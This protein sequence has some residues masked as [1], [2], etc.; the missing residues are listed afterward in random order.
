MCAKKHV[1]NIGSFQHT[2][3]NA[4]WPRFIWPTLY[5]NHTVHYTQYHNGRQFVSLYKLQLQKTII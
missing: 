5:M 3:E 1:I 2:Q 4:E